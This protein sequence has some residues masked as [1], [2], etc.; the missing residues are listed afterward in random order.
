MVKD[1]IDYKEE[2]VMAETITEEVAAGA[3]PTATPAAPTP[4]VPATPAPTP[5]N[6]TPV[7]NAPASAESAELVAH[8]VEELED[9]DK[10]KEIVRSHF[11]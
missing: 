2:V 11:V 7:A 8:P 4:V 3:T 10:F 9:F 1:A 6:P 5:A